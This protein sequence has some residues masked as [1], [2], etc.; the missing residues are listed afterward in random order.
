MT[1][2]KSE[3]TPVKIIKDQKQITAIETAFE[4]FKDAT[5][6][7]K[8]FAQCAPLGT[9]ETQISKAEEKRH[10]KLT[11]LKVAM[12]SP[13]DRAALA[14]VIN[15]TI[16][17]TIVEIESLKS[18]DVTW[19]DEEEHASIAYLKPENRRESLDN[20]I[21]SLQDLMIPKELMVN[22]EKQS[23][24]G[25]CDYFP[26]FWGERFRKEPKKNSSSKP[27]PVAIASSYQA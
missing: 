15:S 16:A 7:F 9:P 11:A 10:D 8:D 25:S 1:T 24:Y 19:Y 18:C 2:L 17:H 13:T 21:K 6:T 5:E 4:G 23:S 26:N 3:T 20:Q 12:Q 22:M 14:E 27:E